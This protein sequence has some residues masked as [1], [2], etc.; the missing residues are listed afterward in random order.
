MGSTRFASEQDRQPECYHPGFMFNDKI[1]GLLE[2]DNTTTEEYARVYGRRLLTPEEELMV[3]VLDEAV[4][5]YQRYLM[6]GSKSSIKRL[7][8]LEKW[9]LED[10][11]EWIFSFVNCCEVLGIRPGYIRRRLLRWKEEKLPHVPLAQPTSNH[12]KPVKKLLRNA[13]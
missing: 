8:E 7:A 4:A 1:T 10:D 2:D 12:K 13:A 9:I 6:A 11:F 3:A 5:D